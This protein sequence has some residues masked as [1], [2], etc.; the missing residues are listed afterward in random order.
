MS[1]NSQS[2]LKAILHIAGEASKNTKIELV[3]HYGT[4]KEFVRVLQAALDPLLSYGV[5]KTTFPNIGSSGEGHFRDATWYLL[6]DLQARKLTGQ[7][8]IDQIFAELAGLEPDSQELLRRIILKDLKAGFS[9]STVNKA[10]PGTIA[11]FP[12]MR[13]SLPKAVKLDKIDWKRGVFSQEKADGMFANIDFYDGSFDVKVRSRQGNEFPLDQFGPLIH[14]VTNYLESGFEYHGELLVY[15]NGKVLPRELSNG[16]MNRVSSGGALA[17]G[18]V[19]RFHVWDQVPLSAIKPK[20]VF[21]APYE[22]RWGRLV[23]LLVE[24]PHDCPIELIDSVLCHSY[25]EVLIHCREK[26]IQGKEGTIAKLATAIWKDGTS[27]EQIKFKLEA[28]V[29]LK[30]VGFTPGNGKN[31][32]TF[33][34]VQTETADGLLAVDVSGMSDAVRAEIHSKRDQLIGTIMTVKG[35]GVMKSISGKHSIFLPRFV[36]L[37]GDKSEADT[38][39]QVLDQFESAVKAA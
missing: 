28:D 22:T 8:A 24:T 21:N 39:Q 12:Y 27:K 3:K 9:E 37:R 15:Y 13:C 29:D 20:G 31:E 25:E 35:N 23:N 17:E 38:Y 16:V 18:E 26:M 10:L 7:A 4:H 36:E 14:A 1:M 19:I 34:S 33:G 32:A 11:E 30:I 5:A 2:I 6:A